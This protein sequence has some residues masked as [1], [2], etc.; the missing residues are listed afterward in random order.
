M[1]IGMDESVDDDVEKAMRGF[2]LRHS[3]ADCLQ[4]TQSRFASRQRQQ[5]TLHI[6]AGVTMSVRRSRK[7][8][9]EESGEAVET[10]V[11][12]KQVEHD[13]TATP[14]TPA[15]ADGEVIS[16]EMQDKD[17]QVWEAF[18]EEFI[19]CE[20]TQYT[21]F[22]HS[23]S[24]IRHVAVEQLPLTLH[25][26]FLLMRELDTLAICE[27]VISLQWSDLMLE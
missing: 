27:S 11:E 26:Q 17:Q 23:G 22:A 12:E 25:R 3:A 16:E 2:K 24:L 5:R 6:L 13:G 19:E 9:R 21:H 4:S 14:T 20:R 18:R 1:S 15:P 7:R 8:K 10:A